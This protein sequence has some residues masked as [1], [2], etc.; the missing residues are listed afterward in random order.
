LELVLISLIGF[1]L[2]FALFELFR[3]V[4]AIY[5]QRNAGFSQ[6]G[7]QPMFPLGGQ[8]RFHKDSF[9]SH[10]VH[11]IIS[12]LWPMHQA[13][14]I[15]VNKKTGSGVARTTHVWPFRWVVTLELQLM[16]TSRRRKKNL[17]KY[18]YYESYFD[19]DAIPTEQTK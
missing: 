19:G 9:H 11:R 4:V 16:K 5:I 18:R 6:T 7:R 1:M 15:R 3:W 8:F 17:V 14:I 2:G 10:H 12:C 13:A